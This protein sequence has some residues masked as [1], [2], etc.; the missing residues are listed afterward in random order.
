MWRCEV[1]SRGWLLVKDPQLSL[2]L[3]MCGVLKDDS[4]D[5]EGDD[6]KGVSLAGVVRSLTLPRRLRPPRLPLSRAS[7]RQCLTA[8]TTAY[9][10]FT[11]RLL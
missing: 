10:R 11:P 6:T 5:T 9:L 2:F 4:E 3:F 7:H 1:C 8:Q